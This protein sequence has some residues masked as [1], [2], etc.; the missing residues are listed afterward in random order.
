[1][2][3]GLT[4]ADVTTRPMTRHRL[5]KAQSQAL[6]QMLPG[7]AYA[8][9]DLDATTSTMDSLV[10]KGLV[11]GEH[12]RRLLTHLHLSWMY[13]LTEEGHRQKR[14]SFSH[15]RDVRPNNR[16]YCPLPR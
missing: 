5:S 4:V 11:V 8:H 14:E 3:P 13:T 10:R 16:V 12:K 1:M 2:A 6:L 15:V 7:E 9:T